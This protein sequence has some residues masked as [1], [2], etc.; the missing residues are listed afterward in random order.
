MIEENIEFIGPEFS[1]HLNI[2]IV[3]NEE[4]KKLKDVTV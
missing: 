2:F 1:G 3:A 4:I